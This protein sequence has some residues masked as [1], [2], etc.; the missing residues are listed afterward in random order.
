MNSPSKPLKPSQV[1]EHLGPFDRFASWVSDMVAKAGFFLL[2]VAVVVLWAPSILILPDVNTW[3]LIINTL[4][5][6]ITFLLVALLQNTQSRADKATQRKLNALADALADLMETFEPAD[7][8]LVDDQAE[9]RAAVGLEH[10][11]G[12]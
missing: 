3:Q 12:S 8:S 11:E 6:I 5:T 7:A 4:T 10:R 2:C 9:L 1:D